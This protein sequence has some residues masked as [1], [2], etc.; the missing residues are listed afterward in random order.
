MAFKRKRC[1]TAILSSCLGY[2]NL[3]QET[4]GSISRNRLGTYS[5]SQRLRQKSGYLL[6]TNLARDMNEAHM[7]RM[8]RGLVA[9]GF[10]SPYSPEG[11]DFEFVEDALTLM[12]YRQR[13]KQYL[14]PAPNASDDNLS[15]ATG[16]ANTPNVRKWNDVVACQIPSTIAVMVFDTA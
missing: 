10:A 4:R 9:V 12:H 2:N 3:W 7:S 6:S 15:Q 14:M 5:L 13:K 16:T 1:K 8:P 11:F